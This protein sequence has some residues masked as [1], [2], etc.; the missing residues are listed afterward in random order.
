MSVDVGTPVARRP[1][2]PHRRAPAPRRDRV[3]LGIAAVISAQAVWLAVLMNRGWYYQADFSNLAS[4][5]GRSLSPGY[6]T[7]SQGGHLGIVGRLVLWLLNRV[8]PLDHPLTILLRVL[9][10]AV[11]SYLLARVLI[12]LVGKRTGVVAVVALYAFSP[13]LVQS[14]LWVT[15]AIG[16]QTSQIFMLLTVLWHLRYAATGRLRWAAATAG[17]LAAA[18]LCAEQAA[19]IALVLPLLTAAYLHDGPVRARLRAVVRAWPEWLMIVA[20]VGLLAAV[21]LGTGRYHQG[22]VGIGVGTALS[23]IGDEL[24]RAVT[25]ALIG[26]PLHWDTFGANYFAFTAPTYPLRV[27]AGL[28]VAT[29]VVITVRRTGLRALVAWSMPVLVA[30]AG[31]VAVA[32]GRYD[33]LGTLITHQLDHSAWT[34]VPAA[35]ALALAWWP[36]SPARIRARATRDEA[37]A[38]PLPPPR[39]LRRQRIAIAAALGTVLVLSA[40]SGIGY[41]NEWAKS[42]A[43]GYVHNLATSLDRAGPG[44]NLFDTYIDSTVV[45]GIEPYRHLSDLTELMG[46][47]PHFDQIST[48]PRVV[49]ATGHIVTAGFLPAATVPARVPGNGFCTD[50]VTG[51]ADLRQDL[52]A[53]PAAN[54]WYLRLGYFQQHASTI[55]IWLTDAHGR[56]V[57]SDRGSSTALTGTLNVAYLHFPSVAPVALHIRSESAATNLCVVRAS[58]G[59]PFPSTP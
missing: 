48:T 32:L 18:A 20:P 9:A 6:L 5:T 38:P 16:F 47:H 25:P 45:P 28:A 52:D 17:S 53:A 42:P 56:D 7:A 27:I 57:A 30:S 14:T 15:S 44:V 26:G 41:S 46:K 59:Y 19:L 58:V 2:R 12:V 40:I 21:I 51:T 54:E 3:A 43:R 22:H 31:I 24:S 23:L 55:E 13:L 11:A 10:Q 29:V 34:A 8:G 33:A 35:M 49:D 1:V 4:A 50:P 36:T 37:G 39:R